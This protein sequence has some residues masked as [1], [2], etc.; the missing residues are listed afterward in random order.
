MLKNVF[1]KITTALIASAM[2]FSVVGCGNSTDN[3]GSGD[4]KT[5]E[6]VT[7]KFATYGLLEKATEQFYTKMASD[8]E[9]ENPD[10]KIEFISYPYGDLKQQVLVMA[11]AG[12]APDVVHGETSSFNAYVSSG[13]LE[14]LDEL[15]S[16]EYIDDIYPGVK[17]AMSA[18][19]KL[20]AA[21][22]ICSPYVMV[23]NKDLFEQAGLDPNAPP[24]TYEEMVDYAEKISQLKDKDGNSVYGLGETTASVPI[25][26]NSVLSVMFS[27]G[28]GIYNDKGEVDVNTQQN[29]DA[30]NFL[31]EIYTNKLNPETA[32]LKDLRNLMAIGRLGMYFDQVW[33]TSGVFGINPEIKEKVA[34]APMPATKATEGLSLLE[35]HELLIMKD[36]KNKEAAAKFVQFATSEKVLQEYYNTL[37][38]LPG[39]KSVELTGEFISPIKDSL[40]GV[41]ALAKQNP[42]MENA[43]LEITSAVQAATIGN[44]STEDAVKKL[45]AKLKEI[46]K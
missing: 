35:A 17:D 15:L 24:K 30:F 19:G 32:K 34:I 37:P 9:A 40:N 16:K 23:Y 41:K 1:K 33:G 38:F 42:N 18:D 45:D 29:I 10:I 28:G 2:V 27:Y 20:Y 22:W 46:L 7:I 5:D 36:S 14:P 39:T 8:F 6:K 25:S 31:K 43:L 21:P 3:S 13:Y 4:A 11:N 26:G 44:E 12:D